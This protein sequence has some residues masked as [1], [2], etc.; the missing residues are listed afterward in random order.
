MTFVLIK[1]ETRVRRIFRFL[2]QYL[3]I[4]KNTVFT[5]YK[6]LQSTRKFELFKFNYIKFC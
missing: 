4:G 5:L 3:F 1:D 6:I 2:I